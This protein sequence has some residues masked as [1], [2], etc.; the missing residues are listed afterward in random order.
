MQ[1]DDTILTLR[2]LE[3]EI[4]V[5]C[6]ADQIEGLQ[7]AAYHLDSKLR[8]I[9][10]AGKVSGNDKIFLQAALELAF[11]LQ[12]VEKQKDGYLDT[13]NNRIRELQK[14]IENALV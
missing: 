12:S 4:Q 5:K 10:D 3:K 1:N 2:L 13:M 9:R 7:Q 11:E 8:V 14:K 6:S